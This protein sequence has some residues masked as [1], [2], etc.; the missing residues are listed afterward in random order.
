MT[1]PL[2]PGDP[3]ALGPFTLRERLAWHSAGTVF[4]GYDAQGR[5]GVL[6]VLHAGAA[7]DPAVR[8]R[9]G[10][11]VDNLAVREPGRV[12][13]AG[14]RAPV[15]WVAT[16]HAG[17]AVDPALRLLA[18]AAAM[19]VVD[20]T[21]AGPGQVPGT[22]P[23]L[24]P[25]TPG[26]DGDAPRPVPLAAQAGV[27]PANSSRS[28]A[29]L[30]VAVVTALAVVVGGAFVIG[31]FFTTKKGETS[32][33]GSTPTP[34]FELTVPPPPLP[35]S[36]DFT[37]PIPE[38][39]LSFPG[40]PSLPTSLPPAIPAPTRSPLAS[41]PAPQPTELDGQNGL[42]VGPTFG[43]NEPTALQ[44]VNDLPFD[45]RTPA[46]WDCLPVDTGPPGVLRV[47]C[48]DQVYAN[49]GLVEEGPGGLIDV[50]TCP[51]PCGEVERTQVR[52]QASVASRTWQRI[53]SVTEY[54]EVTVDFEGSTQV[55][56]AMSHVFPST[57]GGPNNRHVMVRFAGPPQEL[58]A[59]QKV[60]NDVRNRTP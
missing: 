60:I 29:I 24:T 10:R 51:A 19:P 7:A 56:V 40:L 2:R 38:P 54:S 34:E 25:G 32:A 46:S 35:G 8:D 41:I 52:D 23:H 4:L 21:G 42:V 43:E 15:P 1:E 14:L 49:A 27:R 57:P 47:A 26:S 44:D 9:F 50:T 48:L 45:F 5:P 17:N 6:T 13:T 53:D 39:T 18:G 30:A 11:E 59:M 31:G 28:L 58:R 20:G 36:T 33:G 22:G 37:I 3:S 55:S 12:L 16:A